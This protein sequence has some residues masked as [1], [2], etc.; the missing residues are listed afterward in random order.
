VTTGAGFAVA[1]TG[2]IDIVT[3]DRTDPAPDPEDADPD[4][5]ELGAIDDELSTGEPPDEDDDRPW[6]NYVKT[7]ADVDADAFFAAFD[8]G[9]AQRAADAA[10][11]TGADVD[12]E[13]PV[14]ASD[15]DPADPE[16]DERPQEAAST[17]SPEHDDEGGER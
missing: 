8:A 14:D 16:T 4:V 13:A 15:P 10:A 1:S 7:D 2:V 9:D 11:A 5:K 6:E 3:P 17:R 12:A